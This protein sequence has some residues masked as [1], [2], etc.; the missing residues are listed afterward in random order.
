MMCPLSKAGSRSSISTW[1]PL[2]DFAFASD[3]NAWQEECEEAKFAEEDATEEPSFFRSFNLKKALKS[4]FL[5]FSAG[6]D[7]Q[8]VLL[9]AL[10]A[11]P[12]LCLPQ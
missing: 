4:T 1:P 6:P 12:S 10:K 3:E 7:N 11:M 9:A 8:H 2:L 5:L